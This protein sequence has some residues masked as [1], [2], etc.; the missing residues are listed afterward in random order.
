MKFKLDENLDPR[1]AAILQTAGHDAVTV[2]DQ[3][4]QG[5][6]DI[7]VFEVCQREQRCLITLDLDFSNLLDFPPETSA[8]IVI[9][10]HPKPRLRSWLSLTEQLS[11]ALRRDDPTGRLW[12]VEPNRIRIHQV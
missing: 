4:L 11:V 5:A 1:A 12:I 3:S 2:A 8:G 10:R 9:L 7:S 6:E